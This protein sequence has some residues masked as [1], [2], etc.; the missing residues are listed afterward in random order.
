MGHR[1]VCPAAWRWT[2]CASRNCQCCSDSYAGE[3]GAGC[4]PL[5]ATEAASG[6][7]RTAPSC[8]L[9]RL[10]PL[11]HPCVLLLLFWCCWAA[12]ATEGLD[13]LMKPG[14]TLCEHS[15]RGN[16]HMTHRETHTHKHNRGRFN[17]IRFCVLVFQCSAVQ[18]SCII[19]AVQLYHQFFNVIFC[20]A[21]FGDVMPCLTEHFW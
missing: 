7:K 3:C 6:E 18:C 10:V 16:T 11:G 17:G 21:L 5:T 8:Q 12:A 2:T 9:A 19:S 15:I 4:C 1:P 14:K 20:L 13:C